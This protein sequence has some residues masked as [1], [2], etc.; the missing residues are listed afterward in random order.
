[1]SRLDTLKCAIGDLARPA[2]IY[3][4]AAAIVACALAAVWTSDKLGLA[5]VIGALGTVLL[6]LV[7]AR[8]IDNVTATKAQA[9]VDKAK[10][11]ASAGTQP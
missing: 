7:G 10:A 1:M 5:A 9:E 11:V 6:G 8:T 2:A 3:M 4:L